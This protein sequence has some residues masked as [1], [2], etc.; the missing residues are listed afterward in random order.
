MTNIKYN[1]IVELLVQEFERE[2]AELEFDIEQLENLIKGLQEQPDLSGVK[3][4]YDFKGAAHYT[5]IK[6]ETEYRG[7]VNFLL[8]ESKEI[9]PAI[10]SYLDD[11]GSRTGLSFSYREYHTRD[12]N[13][14]PYKIEIGVDVDNG[15]RK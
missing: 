13:K 2:G 6:V 1:S 11:L 8:E 9:K 4:K 10:E 14:K 12:R 3:F 5:Y 7:D 15:N